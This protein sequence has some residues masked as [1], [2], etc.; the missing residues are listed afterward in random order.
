MQVKYNILPNGKILKRMS[1]KKVVRERRRL[2]AFR[3]LV[4]RGEMTVEDARNCY[5]SWR[6]SE[7]KNHNAC[8]NTIHE[9]DMLFK[10][11]FPEK[12]VHVKPKRS[13][14]VTEINKNIETEDIKHC[15][16]I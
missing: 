3:R 7:S 4:D 5:L 1:H 13:E 10:A 8:H 12:I 14:V 9:M 6:G 16:T 11:L 15:L 2:K